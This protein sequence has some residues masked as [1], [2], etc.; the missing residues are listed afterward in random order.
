MF[1]S[2]FLT[3]E[4]PF[5]ANKNLTMFPFKELEKCEQGFGNYEGLPF[6]QFHLI[7]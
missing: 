2:Q 6:I 5:V 1:P 7:T 3:L 4:M